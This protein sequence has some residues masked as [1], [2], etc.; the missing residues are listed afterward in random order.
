MADIV[1]PAVEH[2]LL[3]S[4]PDSTALPPDL[5][6]ILDDLDKSDSEAQR[7][8]GGLS[9]AQANWQP[10]E[11]AWSV[12]QCL[13]HLARANT[14]YAAAL[15]AAVKSGRSV[16]ELR[17][18]PIQPPWFSRFFIRILEPP[19]KR[20]LPAPKK[21]VPASR[22]SKEEALRAFLHSQ[23]QVRAVIREGSGLDLNRIRFRNPF[24]RLLRFT[25]GAGLLIVAA[26]DR[27]HLWQAGQVRQSATFPSN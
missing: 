19:P 15:L 12:A 23:E 22:I 18:A 26:H 27:R 3:A 7:I 21:I 6:T 20:K 16:R 5:Q 24:I 4:G 2:P 1:S 11:T 13:D 17:R 14:T 10:R 9:D 25:V 8:I